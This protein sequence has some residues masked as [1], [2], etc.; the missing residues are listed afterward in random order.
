LAS[1]DRG[2]GKGLRVGIVL[3]RGPGEVRGEKTRKPILLKKKSRRERDRRGSWHQDIS[4]KATWKKKEKRCSGLGGGSRTT[5]EEKNFCEGRE[6][7]GLVAK[8]GEM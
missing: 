7:T 4:A 2:K 5:W 3:K 6:K 1:G 8:L